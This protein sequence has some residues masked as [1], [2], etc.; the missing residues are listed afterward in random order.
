[1]NDNHNGDLFMLY[2]PS[3]SNSSI[4]YGS[5]S[6]RFVP[7]VRFELM[8]DSLEDYEY[9]YVLNN[10]NQPEVDQANA[11]DTHADKIISGLTS[12]TRDSNFMYN[13]RR[14]IGLKNGGEISSIPDIEVPSEG[15]PGNYYINF[16]DPDGDPTADPLV[17]D[18]KE[19]MKIGIT[20]YDENM[21]YG[22]FGATENFKTNYDPWGSETSE[23]KRSYV[24]DDYAH[25]PN[26]FQFD[27]PNGTYNVELCVG[28]PR[29][30]EAHNKVI[31]E[32]V[33]FINDEAANTYITR[34]DE[35]TVSDGNLTLEVGIWGE[36]TF[37]C[38]LNIEATETPD[39]TTTTSSTTTTSTTS[40]TTTSVGTTTTTSVSPT[41]SSTTTSVGTTTTTS[42]S[43]TTSSTTTSVGTTTTTSVSPTTSSIT[44]SVETT[45][46]TSVSSTSSSTTTSSTTTSVPEE[47]QYH[48]TDYNPQDYKI[49]LSEMLRVQQLYIL[50]SFHC[51]PDGEDGYGIGD[52]DQTCAPHDSDYKPQD[53]RISL[54]ELLRVVQF[55][56]LF[57]YHP[58]PQGEDGFAPRP[59]E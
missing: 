56:N 35:V 40:S 12:Y 27:L 30:S 18:D 20:P 53:W 9:L 1:M 15:T 47:Q 36:Y 11:A 4:D 13:L 14:L 45:T 59:G 29:Q 10:G 31:V 42:V 58:D 52:G 32:G 8:R 49:S 5:N 44:T 22:W 16:Q 50:N 28:S 37:L 39:T 6:H 41:T 57:G 54:S 7:S 17:V 48:S 43:P 55:Y 3:E 2:P 21:G 24:Y 38:Y 26:T 23:L 33:T 46:T 19:Y 25:N 34:T 51:D